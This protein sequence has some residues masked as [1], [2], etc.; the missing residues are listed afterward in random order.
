MKWFTAQTLTF[1]LLTAVLS[2][3][4][5]VAGHGSPYSVADEANANPARTLTLTDSQ[6][7]DFVRC[8]QTIVQTRRLTI[9]CEG[10]PVQTELVAKKCQAVQNALRANDTTLETAMTAVAVAYDYKPVWKSDRLC[11]WQKRYTND[12]D[13]PDLTFGEIAVDVANILRLYR[14]DTIPQS[15]TSIAKQIARELDSQTREKLRKGWVPIASLPP[16]VQELAHQF[17]AYMFPGRSLRAVQRINS[18]LKVYRS[19]KIDVC[20][21]TEVM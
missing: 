5:P 3:A 2:I 18:R 13:I 6:L 8:T 15:N 20:I 9:V 19:G 7:S 21:D 16:H 12:E 1:S 11:L 17:T 10:V 14:A 4:Q